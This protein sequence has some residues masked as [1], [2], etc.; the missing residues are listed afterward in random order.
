MSASCFL[1]PVPHQSN[2]TRVL[3]TLPPLAPLSDTQTQGAAPAANS[4]GSASCL[5]AAEGE[6]DYGY[7]FPGLSASLHGALPPAMSLPFFP[8]RK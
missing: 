8:L 7:T 5:S 2:G 6:I 3:A 1:L 4:T